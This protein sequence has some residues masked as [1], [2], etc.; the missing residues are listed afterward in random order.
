MKLVNYLLCEKLMNSV[1]NSSENYKD[2]L[3]KEDIDKY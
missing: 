2:K 3:N 1:I